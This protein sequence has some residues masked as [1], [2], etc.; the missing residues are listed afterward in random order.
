MGAARDGAASRAAG[1]LH[2]ELKGHRE[3]FGKITAEVCREAAAGGPE[4]TRRVSDYQ[5]SLVP[6][7][8]VR[9]ELGR[10]IW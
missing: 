5:L 8:M 6:I 9:R 2:E 3:R 10:P 1:C 7:C 4:P